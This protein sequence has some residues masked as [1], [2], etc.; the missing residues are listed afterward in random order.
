MVAESGIM[1][2]VAAE[3]PSSGRLRALRDHHRHD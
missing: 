2:G 1:R 3:T